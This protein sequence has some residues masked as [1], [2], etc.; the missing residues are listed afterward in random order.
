MNEQ[1]F[2]LFAVLEPFKFLDADLYDSVIDLVSLGCLDSRSKLSDVDLLLLE[3]VSQALLFFF[4][5]N[6]AVPILRSVVHRTLQT[7][8]KVRSASF[9]LIEELVLKFLSRFFQIVTCFNVVILAGCLLL[10]LLRALLV[11][12]LTLRCVSLTLFRLVSS[13]DMN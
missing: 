12:F 11:D 7:S 13:S 5:H 10:P 3:Q 2:Y 9:Y 4:P 1:L 8:F 6:Y